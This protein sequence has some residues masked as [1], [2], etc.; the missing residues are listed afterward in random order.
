MRVT[1]RKIRIKD[2]PQVSRILC[3]CY[4]FLAK[5]DGFTKKQLAYVIK[6]RGSVLSLHEQRKE[7][8]FIVAV[9]CGKPVGVVAV[10]NNYIA[11]LYV[12]M[13]CHGHGI[14]KKLYRAA[15]RLVKKAGYKTLT[16]ETTGYGAHFYKAM[17]MRSAG[18]R[19]VPDGPLK[20]KKTISFM[21]SL[22]PG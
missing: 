7:Y 4:R 8:K 22:K 2:T 20:G 14:G 12:D 9:S 10:K 1:V 21:K 16:L 6:E 11:K 3:A 15:E 5:H 19:A 17:G 18:H 13:K